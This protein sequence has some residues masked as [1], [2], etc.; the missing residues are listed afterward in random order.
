MFEEDPTF[1]PP[2]NSDCQIWRYMDLSGFL[3]LLDTESLHFTRAD[4]LEDPFEGTLPVPNVDAMR[5]FDESRRQEFGD[6]NAT[7]TVI[8]LYKAQRTQE[9]VSCWHMNEHESAAMWKL[10]LKSDEGIA[11]QSTYNNLV[12]SFHETPDL[13]IYAGM[14][15]YLDF[16]TQ[17]INLNNILL[18]IM[19]KRTS[20]VHER[21]IRAVALGRA[22]SDRGKTLLTLN[23]FDESGVDVAVDVRKLI[24]E[25][26]L[27][28]TT[29]PWFE[30]L[31][32]IGRAHV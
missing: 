29:P 30:R 13:V 32:K 4:T 27:A 15:Q 26:R 7:D 23:E 10:Y 1:H 31:I 3:H 16:Q 9:C 8:S 17:K 21:E 2:D 18:P 5:A 19:H 6:W 11:I 28:P 20:F 25:V 22:T 14:V 12:A 24:Q